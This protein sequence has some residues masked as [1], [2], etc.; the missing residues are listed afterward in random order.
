MG[1]WYKK[2][3]NIFSSSNIVILYFLL[4]GEPNN[5]NSED[6][7]L[8]QGVNL[9]LVDVKCSVRSYIICEKSDTLQ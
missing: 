4:L 9:F 7:A 5:L 1:R 3:S 2:N 8:V 6:C